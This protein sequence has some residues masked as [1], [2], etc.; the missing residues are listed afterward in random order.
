VIIKRSYRGKTEFKKAKP[1]K[2]WFVAQFRDLGFFQLLQDIEPPNIRAA[3]TDG[4]VVRTGSRIIIEVSD[5]NTAINQ[6]IG[7]AN[8]VWLMFQ[9]V[10]NKYIYTVDEHLPVG[11]HKLS[12]VVYDEAGNSST[13]EWIIKRL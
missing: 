9:P 8:D 7:K 10:G 2:G 6:F 11:E 4:L 5:N 12:V 13:R 1:E 3:F